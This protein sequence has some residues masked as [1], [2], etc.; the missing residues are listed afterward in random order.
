MNGF[1]QRFL[2][3]AN[4]REAIGDLLDLL[5]LDQLVD[6]AGAVIE[7]LQTIIHD[8]PVPETGATED[9]RNFNEHLQA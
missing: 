4:V 7:R 9:Y 2:V 8:A 6:R 3:S 5:A 1:R